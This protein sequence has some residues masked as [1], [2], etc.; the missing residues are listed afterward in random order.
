M[1]EIHSDETKGC[2]VRAKGSMSTIATEMILATQYL[3]DRFIEMSGKEAGA[4]F[5]K[6]LIN[7]MERMTGLTTEELMKKKVFEVEEVKKANQQAQNLWNDIA[8]G[9]P[10]N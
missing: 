10:W 4:A 2:E 9:K 5:I 8:G 1:L 3:Q 7:A 6:S